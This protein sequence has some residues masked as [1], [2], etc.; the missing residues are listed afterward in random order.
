MS[1]L[2]RVN[3]SYRLHL[4]MTLPQFLLFLFSVFAFVSFGVNLHWEDPEVREWDVMFQSLPASKIAFLSDFH[5]VDEGDL[6]SFSV[7][8]EQIIAADPDVV[9]FGGDYSL[10]SGIISGAFRQT[11]AQSLKALAGD[12]PSVA[13]LGDHDHQQSGDLWR[14][15]LIDAGIPV[16]Q[17][18]IIKLDINDSTLCIRGLDDYFSGHWKQ[19]L[20]PIECNRRTI[21]VTHDPYG[22][23]N[24]KGELETLSIAGHTHCGQIFL[25]WIG[26]LFARTSAPKEMHCGRYDKGEIGITSGGLGSSAISLRWGRNTA[27]GWELIV[28]Q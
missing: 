6:K 16:L 5:V 3:Q 22:L 27:P 21:T 18:Q 8:R 24:S 12:K 14:V 2:V 10:Q 4:E 9:I 20:I 23:L 28:V 19:V 13:V 11:I 15:A 7:I 17:N 1:D 25:P 26:S